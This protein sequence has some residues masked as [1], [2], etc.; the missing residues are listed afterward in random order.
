[1]ICNTCGLHTMDYPINNVNHYECKQC[2]YIIK[3]KIYINNKEVYWI[4]INFDNESFEFDFFENYSMLYTKYKHIEFPTIPISFIIN[5]NHIDISK[6]KA[7]IQTL[8]IL[9]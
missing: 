8:L 6:I 5:D 3:S 9:S 7:K 2:N 4:L 1:M